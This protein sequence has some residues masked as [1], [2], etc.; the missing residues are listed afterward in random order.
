[1]SD[2]SSENPETSAAKDSSSRLKKSKFFIKSDPNPAKDSE[3]SSPAEESES[4][5]VE[6]SEESDEN[7]YQPDGFVV[8]DEDESEAEANPFPPVIEEPKHEKVKKKKRKR[9]RKSDDDYLQL[10]KD[11]M[12]D[13]RADPQPRSKAKVHEHSEDMS[14]ESDEDNPRM[15]D[16]SDLQTLASIFG[17]KPIEETVKEAEPEF[18][19]AEKRERFS[20]NEY[21]N[22]MKID[23]PERLQYRFKN[24]ENPSHEELKLEAEWLTLRLIGF[25]GYTKKELEFEK[26]YFKVFRFLEFYR[27][28]NYE[29]TYMAVYKKHLL[30]PE[31]EEKDLWELEKWDYEWAFVWFSK[32]KFRECLFVAERNT[33]DKMKG[34]ALP[35]GSKIVR[36]IEGSQEIIPRQV[37]ELLFKGYSSDFYKDILDIE[38]W[39]DCFVYTFKETTL[40]DLTTQ[41]AYE[42]IPKFLKNSGMSALEFSENLKNRELIYKSQPSADHP[43]SLAF[44]F[45]GE[46]FKDVGKVL[47]VAMNVCKKDIASLPY[48]RN[49]VRDEYK[50]HARLYTS[51]TESG[52]HALDLYHPQYGVKFIEGKEFQ[53]IDHEFWSN[54][55]KAESNGWITVEFRLSSSD[56]KNDKI[57]SLLQPLY[58]N[59]DPNDSDLKWNEFKIEVLQQALKEIYTDLGVEFYNDLCSKTEDV[60]IERCKSKYR[61]MVGANPLFYE[62]DSD[63][64]KKILVFVTDPNEEYFGKTVSVV[65]DSNGQITEFNEYRTITCRNSES[66]KTTDKNIYLKEKNEIKRIL[67]DHSPYAI[68]IAANCLHSLNIRRYLN[69]VIKSSL[70]DM[71]LEWKGKIYMHGIEIPKL[72][73]SSQRSKSLLPDADTLLRIAVS[74]GRVCLFPVAETLSLSSNPNENLTLL[75]NL[76]PMQKLVNSKRLEWQLENVACQI[77]CSQQV[78]INRIIIH[79][80]LQAPLAYVAGLGHAKAYKLLEMIFKKFK[81]KLKMRASLIAKDC[82]GPKVYEN[83]AGFIFIPRDEEMTE[84][85][86]STRIHPEHYKHALMIAMSAL[87]SKG[88]KEDEAISRIMREPKL[89]DTLDL[90]MYTEK[91]EQRPEYENIKS[92]FNF[93]KQELEAPSK[94]TTR[95]ECDFKEPECLD[96]LYLVSGETKESLSENKLVSANVIGYDEKNNCLVV[97]LE[98]G[99]RGSIDSN[100]IEEDKTLRS[101]DMK[102]YIKGR[103]LTARVLKIEPLKAIDSFRIKLSILESDIK[104]HGKFLSKFDESFK[105]NEEDWDQKASLENDEYRQGQKY[106]PRVVNHPRFKNIALTTACTLLEDKDIGE[107]LF[108]PS[109]RGQDHL[110]CTWKFYTNVFAHLDIIEEGKPATN[111]LG[112]KF[113][114]GDESYDSLQEIIDRYIMPCEKLTKEAIQ[115]PKFKDNSVNIIQLLKQE[116][117]ANPSR[118]PYYFTI[119]EQY[120][121]FLLLHYVPKEKTVTEYIK[122]KPRGLFFHEAY[123]TSLNYLVGWFKRHQGERNY[124]LQLQ[125]TKPPLIDTT[126]HMSIKGRQEKPMTPMRPSQTT[127]NRD[128][129]ENMSGGDRTPDYLDRNYDRKD[130]RGKRTPRSSKSEK[131]ERSERGLLDRLPDGRDR[132]ERVDRNERFDKNERGD[133]DRG[134]REKFD[135]RGT[136]GHIAKEYPKD[137]NPKCYTCNKTGHVAKFCPENPR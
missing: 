75:L 104:Q 42:K 103:S 65:M 62:E 36:M 95:K 97:K 132:I 24:R 23:M 56:Y 137:N 113:K 91:L 90:Q 19:P 53:K 55:W 50:K 61:E 25:H 72:F 2:S 27:V 31:L 39:I 59:D 5:E 70:V 28:H 33:L 121:Q 130:N 98:S 30:E 54:V 21:L 86:D 15:H 78:D 116:K 85:L 99:L 29:I 18:E 133:R 108:R 16:E 10:I 79:T 26:V 35:S 64:T 40:N 68:V 120:P 51:P 47:S 60:I 101:E 74:L 44:D 80:H 88:S 11:H 114:I 105:K 12:E 109:S 122:V 63:R 13:D 124:Q 20:T 7:M 125:K 115:N 134:N 96:L 22:I 81:G 94:R 89:I 110:T 118:I 107:C 32:E 9:L 8:P 43:E 100:K 6:E 3:S 52:K 112:T 93:I 119:T 129:Y 66:L 57:L 41:A 48:V 46:P 87:E 102:G 17:H 77:V 69:E 127:P 38:K 73:S 4:N 49:F 135:E 126:S 128:D 92:V 76:D 82:I 84:P 1:M 67:A 37:T 117:R 14:E 58:L 123:H 83:A 111:M 131:S 106:V 45:L 71:N 136:P 34:E